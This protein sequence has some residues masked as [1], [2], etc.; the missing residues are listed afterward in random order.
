LTTQ[1]ETA[2]AVGVGVGVAPTTTTATTILKIGDQ[3][4]ASAV[5]SL[6]L[7]NVIR[8]WGLRHGKRLKGSKI[9]LLLLL[10]VVGC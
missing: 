9:S 3:G 8:T 6:W 5:F 4:V 1:N 10:L 2:A 7:L